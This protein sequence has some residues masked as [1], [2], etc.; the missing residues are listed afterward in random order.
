VTSE[1]QGS[2]DD[3]T[4]PFVRNEHPI[5][6][7]VAAAAT[8]ERDGGMGQVR[9]GSHRHYVMQVLARHPNGLT[10]E[11]A[12]EIALVLHG[13]GRG[14]KSKADVGRRRCDD[15]EDMAL[16]RPAHRCMACGAAIDAQEHGGFPD[17]KTTP[18]ALTELGFEVLDR[19]D[20]ER[21]V[22]VPW[23]QRGH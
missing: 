1:S 13:V 17:K 14:T 6:S 3:W 5:T 20:T 16:I 2:F 7:H 9:R 18:W 12:G 19:L 10:Q 22:R 8:V 23:A 15:L 4:G 21:V 11:R